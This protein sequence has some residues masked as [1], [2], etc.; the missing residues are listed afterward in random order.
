MYASI[1]PPPN[2]QI[3]SAPVSYHYELHLYLISETPE[4]WASNENCPGSSSKSFEY[5]SP[6]SDA[7]IK[8]NFHL[9]PNSTG[10]FFKNINLGTR[11]TSNPSVCPQAQGVQFIDRR[12]ILNQQQHPSIPTDCFV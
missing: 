11:K 12:L 3:K 8:I 4:R 2:K 9:V 10:N 6:P 1:P 7:S 5:I